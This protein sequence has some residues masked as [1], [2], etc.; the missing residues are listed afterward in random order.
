MP[1]PRSRPRL[2]PRPPTPAPDFEETESENSA[3][4]TV[5]GASHCGGDAAG[6]V[7]ECECQRL[8]QSGVTNQM[9]MRSETESVASGFWRRRSRARRS[10]TDFNACTATC[11]TITRT[12]SKAKSMSQM[13]RDV[14]HLPV[15]ATL[16]AI[17][18]KSARTTNHVAS[19]HRRDLSSKSLDALPNIPKGPSGFPPQIKSRERRINIADFLSTTSDPDTCDAVRCLSSVDA[20]VPTSISDAGPVRFSSDTACDS[21]AVGTAPAIS[22]LYPIQLTSTSTSFPPAPLSPASSSTTFPRSPYCPSDLFDNSDL[23]QDSRVRSGK[24]WRPLALPFWAKTKQQG[25]TEYRAGPISGLSG[26]KISMA[27]NHN[28][29][30]PS[31]PPSSPHK[32]PCFPHKARKTHKDACIRAHSH[33]RA[34]TTHR[35]RFDPD[36]PPVPPLPSHFRGHAHTRSMFDPPVHRETNSHAHTHTPT[37]SNPLSFDSP[38]LPAID[39]ILGQSINTPPRQSEESDQTRIGV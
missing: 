20:L 27:H 2:R 15:P 4:E 24:K 1:P 33:D 8:R 7:C 21:F 39:R 14:L 23:E 6:E 13:D 9:G 25:A 22:N 32:P 17:D 11:G 38:S 18:T 3:S 35:F 37:S 34:R 19:R 28:A 29:S 5:F 31:R 30:P 16:P 10:L 36:A 12:K 26:W